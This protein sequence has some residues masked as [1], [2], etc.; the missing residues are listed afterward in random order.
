V[1]TIHGKMPERVART[2]MR[3]MRMQEPGKIEKGGPLFKL[4]F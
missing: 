2:R 1:A 4:F 3:M